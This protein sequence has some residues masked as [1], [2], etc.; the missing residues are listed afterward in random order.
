M[1]SVLQHSARQSTGSAA[2]IQIVTRPKEIMN[3]NMQEKHRT[4]KST[5]NDLRKEKK[6]AQKAGKQVN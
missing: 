3:H 1:L 4:M 2:N 6:Q 5:I